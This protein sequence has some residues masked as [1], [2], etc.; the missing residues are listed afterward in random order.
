VTEQIRVS[1]DGTCILVT[2]QGSP[3][4]AE[5][6][7]TLSRLAELREAHGINH[8]LVDSRA[9]S[10]QPGV[11]DIYRGG[12]L[13]AETLGPQVRIAVLVSR[14]EP[15]HTLFENVAVNRGATV[16]YFEVEEKARSWLFER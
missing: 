2:S 5:M 12:K 3:S 4:L 6:E 15:D 1:L 14:L 7:Q 13:L 16:A 8:V 9:R 11:A 10:G